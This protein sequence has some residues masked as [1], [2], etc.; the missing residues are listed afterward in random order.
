[1]NNQPQTTEQLLDAIRREAAQLE[2]N[3]QPEPQPLSAEEYSG[4]M[5]FEQNLRLPAKPVYHYREFL[6]FDD[7]AFVQNAFLCILQREPDS[8]GL[9]S[10]LDKLRNGMEKQGV[11]AELSGSEEAQRYGVR[12]RGLKGY[13]MI[14]R[15][16]RV[17]ALRPLAH[18]ALGLYRRICELPNSE[19]MS[20]YRASVLQQL[21]QMS[22]QLRQAE[23]TVDGCLHQLE[24]HNLKQTELHQGIQ[25]ELSTVR[26]QSANLSHKVAY[27]QQALAA[28]ATST[29]TKSDSQSVALTS[30]V[31]DNMDISAFY[32]AFE[33]A[34][35]GT[36]EE[37]RAKMT[38]W[39]AYLPKPESG[40]NRV[41]DIGCGR[42]EWLQL[43]GEQHYLATGLDINPVMV[44][45]CLEQ[46]LDVCAEDALAWLRAQ[47]DASLCAI[48]AFHVIEHVPFELLLRWTTEARRVLQPGG[49]L[50]FETPN[51]ENL[52]VGSH[53]FY[54]DPTHRNPITP[55][56][57]EFLAEYCGYTNSELV[58][59][60]PYPED[61]RVSGNDP[62]TERV[63]GHL[64]G[65]QDIALVARV[66]AMELVE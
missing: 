7:E 9:Q 16:R 19:E 24:Q 65:P 58:R 27:Q 11:L 15:L 5:S 60:H 49:V 61:A 39:L 18:R 22:R 40:G 20:H 4:S 32:V 21:S 13:R 63:N 37:I 10:Y 28:S 42:G 17:R 36:R 48:T 57:L 47:P 38:P 2:L 52:L 29:G 50:I 12:I 56:L 30:A 62:L 66:P 25:Q 46:G 64:C 26:K 59:L 53:T 33:D 1:M 43:L 8:S 44:N 3:T 31:V 41:L 35:R 54:H 14:A 6:P 51:P 34:C 45:S 55:A 23:R